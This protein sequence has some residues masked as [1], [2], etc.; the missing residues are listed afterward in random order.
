MSDDLNLKISQF[1]D[2]ELEHTDAL[3][4]LTSLNRQ[5]E[6][7]HKLNRYAAISHA[8]KSHVYLEVKTG[9]S[10]NIA[11]H[12]QQESVPDLEQPESFK[13]TY[14]W[15][16]LAVSLAIIAFVVEQSFN[17]QLFMPTTTMQMAQN[18]LPEHSDLNKQISLYLQEHSSDTY[19]HHE[20]EVK[21]YAKVT[22]YNQK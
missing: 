4:L 1:M 3:Q 22:A 5:P 7:Q 21:P 19:A 11:Q 15:L 13:Q 8:L 12:I 14:Q 16:T 17:S 2:N 6:L 10:E 18:W 9:F 20:A